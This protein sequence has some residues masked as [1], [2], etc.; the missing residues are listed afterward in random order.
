MA[1]WHNYSSYSSYSSYSRATAKL[2]QL[3]Q[4]YSDPSDH[5]STHGTTVPATAQLQ[6][7]YSALQQLQCSAGALTHTYGSLFRLDGSGGCIPNSKC[8]SF[9]NVGRNVRNNISP[10]AS[11]QSAGATRGQQIA[12]KIQEGQAPLCVGANASVRK[13]RRLR[14][15]D[16][17]GAFGWC[18]GDRGDASGAAA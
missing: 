18:D 3:Q 7:S 2:Q 4:S 11:G 17:A 10:L 14:L 8:S 16:T 15:R 13:A 9:F 6:R 1:T 12:T 5:A